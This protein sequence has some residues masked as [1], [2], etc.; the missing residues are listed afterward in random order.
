MVTKRT[1]I[2]TRSR[3]GL[4]GT[5]PGTPRTRGS[6][7]GAD[8]R[9]HLPID[10][11]ANLDNFVDPSLPNDNRN[12]EFY[13]ADINNEDQSVDEGMRVERERGEGVRRSLFT[14]PV[15]VAEEL[16]GLRQLLY[17]QQQQID[18]LRA[19]PARRENVEAS[20]LSRLVRS[21]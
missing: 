19:S 9:D 14:V 20:M 2:K 16:R 7:R 18:E 8:R 17:R 15:P 12:P 3:T 1:P 4:E 11:L 5:P 6:N 21:I 10:P 13:R